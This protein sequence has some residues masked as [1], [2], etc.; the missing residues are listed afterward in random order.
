MPRELVLDLASLG[1]QP[2]RSRYFA[3]TP[4]LSIK[5]HFFTPVDN[6]AWASFSLQ[7]AEHKS[8]HNSHNFQTQLST[9]QNLLLKMMRSLFLT[10][11]LLV[12]ASTMDQSNA[13]ASIVRSLRKSGAWGK[14]AQ[15]KPSFLAEPMM[16]PVNVQPSTPSSVRDAF[17]EDAYRREM[18]D[19]VY[20]RNLDRG[21]GQ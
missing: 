21:F 15:P 17:D 13:L 4:N 3:S 14:A 11:F 7:I 20:Q 12:V 9:K 16:A 19:F 8:N 5:G 10:L 6:R 18:T 2:V 1:N